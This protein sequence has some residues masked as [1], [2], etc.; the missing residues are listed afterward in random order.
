MSLAMIGNSLLLADYLLLAVANL[1]FDASLCCHPQH[2]AMVYP[3][4]QAARARRLRN[5]AVG[6]VALLFLNLLEIFVEGFTHEYV[7]TMSMGGGLMGGVGRWM[8]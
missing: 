4:G 2:Q 6:F 5:A 1:G 8:V 3:R 7:R